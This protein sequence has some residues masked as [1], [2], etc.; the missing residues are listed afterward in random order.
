MQDK[1]SILSLKVRHSEQIYI[2]IRKSTLWKTHS[3]EESDGENLP[4]SNEKVLQM[5][6]LNPVFI[7]FR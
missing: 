1:L 2:V 4:L 7:P 3:Q 6:N 5:H